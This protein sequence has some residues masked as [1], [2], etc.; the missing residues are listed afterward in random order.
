MINNIQQALDTILKTWADAV[1]IAVAWENLGDQT[2]I[3]EP[4]VASF[5][6]PAETSINGVGD[7]D[8]S[9]FTGIYQ[10]NVY[11]Q[12]GDGTIDSRPLVDGLLSAFKKGTTSQVGAQ[13]VRIVNSWRS[14]AIDNQAWYTI[15][16]SVRYRSFA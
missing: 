6:L 4:H 13:R 12:K 11:V 14:S 2:D 10:V 16:V 15:P 1:T 8:P 9:D 5:L 3:D 7:N